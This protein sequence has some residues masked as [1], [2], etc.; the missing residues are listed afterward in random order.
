VIDC[1][2][3]KIDEA[4]LVLLCLTMHDDSTGT[5]AWKSH[6]WEAMDRLHQ[7][8]YIG[9]PKSKAKSVVITEEGRM[10]AEQLFRQ[11]FAKTR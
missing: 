11:L 7:K 10:K 5:R 2:E 8:G 9:N 1:D 6:D 3:D 4:V